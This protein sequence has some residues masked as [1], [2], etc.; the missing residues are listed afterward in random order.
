M[1]NLF[2]S[3]DSAPEIEV[4]PSGHI[5]TV[6]QRNDRETMLFVINTSLELQRAVVQF[7]D[8]AE[9]FLQPVLASGTNIPIIAG[10]AEILLQAGV[11]EV[12]RIISRSQP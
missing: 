7:R 10:E 8:P 4:D 9:G 5:Y 2:H 6:I 12:F 1:K 11:V 3:S